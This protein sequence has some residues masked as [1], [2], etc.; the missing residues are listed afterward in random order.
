[1]GKG[2]HLKVGKN[3]ANLRFGI[4]REDDF[5]SSIWRL[6]AT[7][8]GDVYVTTKGQSG[9]HKYSFHQSG[10]CRSAFTSEHGTPKTMGDR[11]MHKWKRSPTPNTGSNNY[12]RLAWIAFPTNYLSRQIQDERKKVNWVKAAPKNDATY[13]E[14]AITSESEKHIK[15]NINSDR[16]LLLYA[17]LTNNDALIVMYSYGEW[18]NNDLNSPAA[19]ESIFPDLLF[20][21]NDP[22]DTGRPIRILFGPEPSDNDALILQELG[23][24]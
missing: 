20:S 19:P 6:W 21:E 13:L 10:I 4:K 16:C 9:I 24:Y 1:M 2:K 3:V 11:L 12:S 14:L 8:H 22:E 5:I 17:P 18:E 15:K 7:K 23:G